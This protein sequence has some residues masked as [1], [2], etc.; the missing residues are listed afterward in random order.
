V[1]TQPATVHDVATEQDFCFR[2]YQEA[3]RG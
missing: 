2:H 1:C 3:R